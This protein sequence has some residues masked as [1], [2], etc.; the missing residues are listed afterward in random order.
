MSCLYLVRHAQA[1]PVGSFC[2]G[3]GTDGSLTKEGVCQAQA[4]HA[5]VRGMKST[6]L[7]ASPLRRSVETAR[8]MGGPDADVR[9]RSALREMNMGV[10]EGKRFTVIREEFPDLY[11]ARGEDHSLQPPGAESF[12]AAAIRMDRALTRIAAPLGAEEERVVVGHSGAIRAFLCRVTGVPYQQNRSLVLPYGGISLVEYGPEGWQPKWIG[13]T[14]D[15][16]PTPSEIETLWREFGA[17]ESARRHCQAVAELA[18]Q[19]CRRLR[20]TG[21][22]LNEELVRSAS[23]LHDL[24]RDKPHHPQVAARLLRREG[25]FRLAAVVALHEEGEDPPEL[26]EEGLVFL[27][28]KLI[29]ECQKTD[30]TT[31][32]ESSLKKCRTVDAIAAHDR[33]LD[34]ALRLEQ[35]C[36]SR[37]E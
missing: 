7:Y 17:G 15:R 22:A 3:C 11:A 25:Y 10:W 26:D 20:S 19:L 13:I 9:I 29:L 23:L 14:A 32:F 12:S 37:I 6:P 33:R 21:L 8:L 18:V 28:D 35:M 1:E 27:A 16:L 36:R 24:C 34:R 2:I 31:R 5:W 30:I 4:A